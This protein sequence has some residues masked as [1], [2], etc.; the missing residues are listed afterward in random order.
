[1]I[2]DDFDEK[3]GNWLRSYLGGP[4]SDYEGDAD[5]TVKE[6]KSYIADKLREFG[7]KLKK[8][9]PEKIMYGNNNSN[10]G[11][12]DDSYSEGFDS[13][14]SC[15]TANTISGFNAQIDA[16]LKELE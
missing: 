14:N 8:E 10:S 7:E 16:E 6:L 9:V 1:M 3:W 11:N 2:L 4:H 13:G 5:K 15:G 12:F